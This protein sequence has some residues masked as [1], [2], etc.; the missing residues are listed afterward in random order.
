[1][2]D[3]DA[4][5]RPF[6]VGMVHRGFG[7]A[8]DS[9]WP[10]IQAAL[11][12]FTNTGQSL[13]FTGHSLGAALATLAVARCLFQAPHTPV[14]GLYTYGSPRAGDFTFGRTFDQEFCDKTFRFVNNC[15][16]V[17]RVP[18]RCLEFSHV[19]QLLYFDGDGFLQDDDHFWNVFLRE[20]EV[21]F[22]SLKDVP[23][24]IEDHGVE[25]YI[26]NLA[27]YIADVAAGQRPPLDC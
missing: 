7:E 21:D 25:H 8:L 5:L 20:V 12:R 11:A 26:Q 2:T 6:E 1:M 9:V 14:N 18:P 4:L 15:D 27:K 13:W 19:G 10:D 23:L 3:L 22:D 24:I 16:L 17:T